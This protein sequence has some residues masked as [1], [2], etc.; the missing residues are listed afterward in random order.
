MFNVRKMKRVKI[1]LGLIVLTFSVVLLSGCTHKS[2]HTNPSSLTDEQFKDFMSRADKLFKEYNSDNASNAPDKLVEGARI[3]QEDY[4]TEANG[5]QLV[6][7]A[8]DDS[9][10]DNPAKAR[11]WAKEIIDGLLQ[12][13]SN[14]GPR[15]FLIA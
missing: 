13:V 5:Y 8:M 10:A 14:H 2:A 1:Q 9:A 4:P 15:D 11:I 6:M 3:L 7:C 12:S